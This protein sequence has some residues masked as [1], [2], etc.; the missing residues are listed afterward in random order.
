MSYDSISSIPKHLLSNKRIVLETIKQDG[1]NL[2]LLSDE[3]RDDFDIVEAAIKDS[4]YSIQYA[5]DRLKNSKDIA[6][7]GMSLN[8]KIYDYLNVDIK[9]DFDV[10]KAALTGVL[11]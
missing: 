10:S 9:K 8:A 6:L 4:Y 2:Y 11:I 1:D 3:M 5:S 7:I